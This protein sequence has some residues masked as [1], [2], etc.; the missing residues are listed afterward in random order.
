M[1]DDSQDRFDAAV[2]SDSHLNLIDTAQVWQLRADRHRREGLEKLA[3][4]EQRFAHAA[5]DAAR[6]VEG[7]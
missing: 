6:E 4:I 3:D 5:E 1:S 7:T 2:K